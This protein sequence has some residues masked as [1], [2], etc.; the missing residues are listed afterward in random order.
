MFIAGRK[1]EQLIVVLKV[2]KV[3]LKASWQVSL[4]I[5]WRNN[6]HLRT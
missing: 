2:N 6:E 5:F 3:D 4:R 1:G